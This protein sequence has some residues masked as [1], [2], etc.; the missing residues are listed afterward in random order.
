MS[1]YNLIRP[2]TDRDRVCFD[3][4]LAPDECNE[5]DPR[6]PFYR[7][8]HKERDPSTWQWLRDAVDGIEP[9][10]RRRVPLGGAK[11][12]RVQNHLYGYVPTPDG[13]KWATRQ[14]GDHLIVWLKE[15]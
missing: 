15:R 14:D 7:D 5:H 12:S 9:G 11:A 6:C 8:R 1:G 4:P 13:Y 10:Q 3:C 2:L